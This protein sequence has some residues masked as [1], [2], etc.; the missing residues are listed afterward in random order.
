M[1]ISKLDFKNIMEQIK[2]RKYMTKIPIW[3][4]KY[5]NKREHRAP[6]ACSRES[7]E[8]ADDGRV[9]EGLRQKPRQ[10][11]D[12]NRRSRCI[13]NNDMIEA[14]YLQGNMQSK[15]VFQP[16]NISGMYRPKM[17]NGNVICHFFH[18]LG[19]CFSDCQH[20][21]S[22]K[23]LTGNEISCFTSFIKKAMVKRKY[24]QQHRND[25]GSA[26]RQTTP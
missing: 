7:G 19:F 26:E 24:Y 11:Q 1:N 6:D 5:V 21:D 20:T 14:C 9:H 3:I 17:Q 2:R 18:S 4:R 15:D 13:I 22:Y 12:N 25:R 10:F 8:D 16:A 23:A